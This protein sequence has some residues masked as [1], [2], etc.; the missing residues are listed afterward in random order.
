M[1]T[2][3]SSLRRLA[4]SATH[5]WARGGW[6]WPQVWDASQVKLPRFVKLEKYSLVPANFLDRVYFFFSVNDENISQKF[7]QAVSLFQTSSLAAG[8][9]N[10]PNN[11]T[12]QISR[13]I[14][15]IQSF[16]I[17]CDY[18]WFAEQKKVRHESQTSGPCLESAGSSHWASGWLRRLRQSQRQLSRPPRGHSAGNGDPDQ[19]T[20]LM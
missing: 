17:V 10:D 2:T 20:L 16:V 9:N 15:K 6:Q 5:Q 11:G 12:N 14:I 3:T 18:S 4:N 19:Q 8:P 1:W 13:E 7:V